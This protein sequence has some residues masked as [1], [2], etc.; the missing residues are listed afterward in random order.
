M[1]KITFDTIYTTGD[2]V[3]END[4]YRHFHYPEMLIQYDSN[5]LEFKQMPTIESFQTAESYLRAY[6]LK[7]NQNHVKFYFPANEK[8]GEQLLTHFNE[9][10]YGIGYLEL[11]AIEPNHF[12]RKAKHSDIDVQLVVEGNLNDYLTLSHEQDME[13]GAA[14][15]KQKIELNKRQFKDPRIKQIIAYYQ[16]IPVGAVDVIL[17]ENTAEIDSLSVRESMRRKGIGSSLQQFVMDTFSDKT[18]ILVADG[19]DTPR[20]MY[21]KQNYQYF[22]FK[23]EILKVYSDSE[24]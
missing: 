17:T 10:G 24:G 9:H 2:V 19:E 1:E 11:Y 23:Y 18:I 8:P 6:H 14:F 13:F 15:A 20:E 12:P 7:H 4:G 22:G 21:K 5:F 16:G 3:F